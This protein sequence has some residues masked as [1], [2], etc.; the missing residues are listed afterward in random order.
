MKKEEKTVVI[1]TLSDP[2]DNKPRYVGKTE[3]TQK[4]RLIIH[5][6]ESKR[7]A[8]T[9][10]CNWIRK[11][12]NERRKPIIEIIDM[13]PEC[14]WKFWETYWISQMKEWGFKL[15]NGTLGGDGQA[16]SHKPIDQYDLDGNFIK[17]WVS[18]T[19][20]SEKLNID[21]GRIGEIC[22]GKPQSKTAGGY[23][24]KF[25]GEKLLL[26]DYKHNPNPFD[27]KPVDQYTSDGIFIKE[28]KSA[29]F[30][31]NKLNIHPDT[32]GKVCKLNTKSKLAGGFIWKY[33]GEKINL[34][35]HKNIQKKSI[36]QYDMEGNF[37]KEWESIKEAGDSLRV[38]PENI[39]KVCNGSNKTAAGYIWK[40]KGDKLVLSEHRYNINLYTPVLQYD[41]N[42]VFLNE[43]RNL[44]EASLKTNVPKNRISNV[45]RGWNKTGSGYK[46]KYKT[47]EV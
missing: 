41:L 46:W 37:I 42:D 5:I 11:V 36:N 45:C 15:T 33:Q 44:T 29:E 3:K 2:I 10:K 19:E 20:A 34:E 23:T 22:S 38:T 30:A 27:K 43:Y 31:G 13:V 12:L 24:W 21:G 40:Y 4:R 39:G 9:H 28:W 14:E 17:T 7:G 6:A 18:I 1:Y 16:H 35:D 26:E 25:K 8:T 47:L 32:I